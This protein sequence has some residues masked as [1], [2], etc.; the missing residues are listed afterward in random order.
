MSLVKVGI[1]SVCPA[2]A[3][4]QDSTSTNAV[5][6]N[7]MRLIAAPSPRGVLDALEPRSRNLHYCV[8]FTALSTHCQSA[9]ARCVLFAAT[10]DRSASTTVL[11]QD[12][13]SSVRTA[14]RRPSYFS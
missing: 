9:F 6:R 2:L 4:A 11:R 13:G 7:V 10:A 8:N 3:V 1:S 12:G 5:N 14:D